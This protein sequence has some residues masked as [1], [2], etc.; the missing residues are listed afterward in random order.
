MLLSWS[1]NLPAT[2]AANF[3]QRSNECSAFLDVRFVRFAM[4][5]QA[6]LGNTSMMSLHRVPWG[7]NVL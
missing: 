7:L 5:Y 6:V 3:K 2:I 1:L 4:E